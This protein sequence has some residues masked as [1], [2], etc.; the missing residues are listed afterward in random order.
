[1]YQLKINGS[2]VPCRVIRF[3]DGSR[4]YKFDF[5]ENSKPTHG[6]LTVKPRTK[7]SDIFYDLMQICWCIEEH[8]G[9]NPKVWLNLMI[10]YLPHGRADRVFE[11][12]MCNLKDKTLG[13]LSSMFNEVFV[14]NPHSDVSYFD[15]VT[16]IDQLNCLG[17]LVR[18]NQY[19]YVVAPDK[20]SYEKVKLIADTYDL[21][22]IC[23]DKVRNVSTGQIVS[24][25]TEFKGNLKGRSVLVAD[26]ICDG[27]GT[28]VPVAK[29]LR[30]LGADSVDL[31]V[32][33]M[34]AS[35]GLDLFRG[36]YDNLICNN[37][38]SNYIT[39]EDIIDFNT[40]GF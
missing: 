38:V 22:M 20:G 17:F 35:K 24:I 11:K 26:D 33:H 1:M 4:S 14:E 16:S 3:S 18:P 15:N 7:V 27:G 40:G 25:D 32:T 28:F 23:F 36:I 6:V 5:P 34:I 37:V 9:S 2:I 13:L 10:P 31:Y 21:G 8:Y 39:K 30:D 19:D 12:G 29:K